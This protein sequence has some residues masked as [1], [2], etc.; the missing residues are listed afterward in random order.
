MTLFT[1][2]RGSTSEIRALFSIAVL[3]LWILARRNRGVPSG[4][5]WVA[6]HQR[7]SSRIA[8]K[9]PPSRQGCRLMTIWHFCCISSACLQRAAAVRQASALS[10]LKASHLGCQLQSEAFLRTLEA[11]PLALLS[12]RSC[13]HP[14]L[15][16][17]SQFSQPT[18]RP[19]NNS[20]TNHHNHTV[21]HR[22]NTPNTCTVSDHA[23]PRNGLLLSVLHAPGGDGYAHPG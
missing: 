21:K 15:G 16:G 5:R 10:M 2:H 12:M 3:T 4:P 17:N 9:A 1:L 6:R 7:L 19:T 20:C 14:T 13:E 22:R 8:P 23:V 18:F 11:A